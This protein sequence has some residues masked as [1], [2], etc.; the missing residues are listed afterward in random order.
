MSLRLRLTLLYSVM[1]S[2]VVVLL[3]IVVYTLVSL[4]LIDIV[5]RNLQDN[6]KNIIAH[7]RA[8]EIGNLEVSA[9]QFLVSE[10][11]YFQIWSADGR[12]LDYSA[13]ASEFTRAL[14]ED[15]LTQDQL[16]FNDVTIGQVAYRILSVPLMVQDQDSGWL[17]VGISLAEMRYTLQLLQVVFGITALFGILVAVVIGW[18]VTGQTLAPLKTMADIANRIASM[19]DL[20]QRIPVTTQQSDEISA[21]ALTFNQTFVRL[22]RLFDAQRR[23]LADVSHEFRT[24]LTVIKGNVGLMRLMKSFDD[25]SLTSIEMEVDR[26]TR[27]VRDLLLM[28]Q[29]EVGKLPLMLTSVEIDELLFSVYEEMKVLSAGKHDIRFGEIEPVIITGDRDRLKQVLLNLGSNAVNYTPEGG[30]IYLSLKSHQDWIEI[31]VSDEGQGVPKEEVSRLFERFYRGEKSR[32]R[33]SETVGYGLGLP[34]A[35]WI[36]RNHGGRID[37]DT[38]AGKGTT[39]TVWL[40]KSYKKDSNSNLRNNHQNKI[41]G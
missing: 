40:P 30:R 29:A 39:F 33:E 34:I 22:E 1:L 23:F 20:S 11:Y 21:L 8:D 4:L 27:M 15:G 6:A 36:V 31:V 19:E 26:L 16:I 28:A 3:S 37:V 12:L 13:N 25:E 17:Q 14:D 2:G 5:D 32:T 7:L 24:P 38:A 9:E 41:S 35:Y 18:L 10:A